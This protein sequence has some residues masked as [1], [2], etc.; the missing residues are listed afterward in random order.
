MSAPYALYNRPLNPDFGNGVYRRRIRLQGLPGKVVAELEDCN[1]GFRSVVYHDG[2]KVTAI[3]PEA[4]RV[5]LTTCDGALQPLRD[6]VGTPLS[7]SSLDISRAV[8]PKSQ[9]TH[10]YDLSVLAIHHATRGQTERQF[11]IAIPDEK[12]GPTEATVSL[13]GTVLL[14]WTI[15]NWT[16]C[17]PGQL[18]GLSLGKGFSKWAS[19]LYQ[20]DEQEA[21]FM[22]QKGYFVSGARRYDIAKLAGVKVTEANGIACYSY[23]PER[24]EQAVRTENSTRDF[25]DCEQQLLKFL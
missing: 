23:S 22:L 21:A 19:S 8:N 4:L 11:D 7:L 2:E 16:L 20:G 3:E 14:R 25:T 10:L 9:C 6:L 12:D 15:A 17:N 1:H 5:P 24:M 18:H 13:N